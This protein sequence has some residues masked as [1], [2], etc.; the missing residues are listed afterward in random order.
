MQADPKPVVLVTGATSAIGAAVSRL[1]AAAGWELILWYRS[2]PEEAEALAAEL[3]QAGAACASERV[4]F[5]DAR[6]VEQAVQA[7]RGRRVDAL[8]NNAGGYAAQ[9]RFSELSHAEIMDSLAVNFTAPFLLASALFEGM[10]ARGFG[11]I[12]NISS[13]AA[14]YGG[15]AQSMQYGCAKRALEGITR[16]LAREGAAQNVL[17]NT[18]R[19]GVIDT[20]FHRRLGRDME[21]RIGLIPM[22]RMGTAAE[23]AELVHSLGSARNTYITGQTVAV[24]GGE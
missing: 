16:T 9:K 13:V 8:V 20:G 3:R 19:P 14:K 5:A 22:R 23:V 1:Y 7:L 10:A 6:S 2:R 11:R 21:A 4:D 17:V 12:V 15:S 24:S 18:V